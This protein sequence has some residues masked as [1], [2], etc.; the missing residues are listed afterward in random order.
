MGDLGQ[1]LRLL[2]LRLGV[3]LDSD[4][5]LQLAEEDSAVAGLEGLEQHKLKPLLHKQ[6]PFPADSGSKLSCLLLKRPLE[7]FPAGLEDL[8]SKVSHLPLSLADSKALG[9]NR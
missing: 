2:L 4:C 1:L 7:D 6:Q 9:S 5:K 8:E 3:L